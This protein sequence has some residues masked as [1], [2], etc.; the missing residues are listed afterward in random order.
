MIN[1]HQKNPTSATISSGDYILDDA[2]LEAMFNEKTKMFILNTPN[3]PL[4]KVFTRFVDT[5]NLW[6]NALLL[7]MGVCCFSAKN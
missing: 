7:N 2:E 4:G 6:S 3:N 1:F 5:C